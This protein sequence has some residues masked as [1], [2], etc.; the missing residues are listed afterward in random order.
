[1]TIESRAHIEV[2][3]SGEAAT[4]A[5]L[6]GIVV[7][8]LAKTPPPEREWYVPG[9]IPANTVTILSGDGDSGKT[10]LGLMLAA[11]GTA[12]VPWLGLDVLPGRAIFFSAEDDRHELHRRLA[13]IA[14]AYGITLKDLADLIIVP[15]D[16]EDDTH[17]AVPDRT[18]LLK[19]TPLW[20]RA[21]ALIAAE[22]P[23][24]VVFDP[25]ADLFGGDEVNRLHARQFIAMLRG[26]ARRHR[27]TVV[28]LDH[29]SL[30]GMS[31]GRGTSGSTGTRNSVRSMLYLTRITAKVSE[32][33]VEIDTDRRTLSVKK[34]NYARRGTDMKLRWQAGVFVLDDGTAAEIAAAEKAPLHDAIFLSLVDRYASEG[35]RVSAMPSPNYAPTRFATEPATKGMS[36]AD[37]VATL[38]RLMATGRVGVEEIGPPSRRLTRLVTV[39]DP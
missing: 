17:L 31:S 2:V 25:R 19:P 33:D 1:M 21:E 36:K 34:S 18:G 13:A 29:P 35:R 8:S 30:S 14:K 22:T 16:E 39:A 9:L 23:R 5:P 27:V 24:L 4:L 38:N 26:L 7:S 28:L 15:L 37:L 11:S 12:Q 20:R 10:L 32:G 3:P 6:R